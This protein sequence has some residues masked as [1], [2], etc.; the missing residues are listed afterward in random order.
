M[1]KT[2]SLK[3]QFIGLCIIASMHYWSFMNFAGT[4]I[5]NYSTVIL[6]FITIL[7]YLINR[8]KVNDHEGF[9]RIVKWALFTIFFSI[10]ISYL[11]WGQSIPL[12]IVACIRLSFGL[13][14]YLLLQKWGFSAQSLIKLITKISIIWVFLE[15]IQ[16]FTYPSFWFS[17]RYLMNES[18]E[19]RFGIWRFYIWGVD[20]VM[21]SFSYWFGLLI[22]GDEYNSI[23]KSKR[24]ILIYSIILLLGLL[25][26]GSRKHIF[27]TLL[28]VAYSIL[29]SRNS[30]KKFLYI[31]IGILFFAFLYTEFYQAL[32]E[33]NESASVAQ[34]EGED[35]VRYIAANYFLFEASDSSLYPICGMGVA[36]SSGALRDYIDQLAELRL[37]QSDVGIIGYY[38]MFGILGVSAIIWY[39]VKFLSNWK[40]IDDWFK[41]FFIMKMILIIFDFWAMWGVG[42]FAWAMFLYL[43]ER[44]IHKNK[45]IAKRA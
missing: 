19:E 41:Y 20:F 9:V 4:A 11:E 13:F 18:L 42:M 39:I 8:R 31:T 29:K 28:I 10:F 37:Y 45:I 26:Y 25:C 40:Y 1:F 36:A 22:N 34:G 38:S 2:Q 43:L 17:G 21:I 24:Q 30:K 35:W 44:N 5:T 15:L 7:F 6:C 33:L 16:Q 27:A 3:V 23:A 12:S 14:V 32:M